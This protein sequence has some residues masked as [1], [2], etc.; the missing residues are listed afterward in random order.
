M[1]RETVS[2][3]VLLLPA[4]YTWW[5]GRRLVRRID[6]PAFPELRMAGSQRLFLVVF[7][8]A[9]VAL[10]ISWRFPAAKVA[11]LAI[12]LIVA[13]FPAR[14]QIYNET[15]G[16][17]GYAAHV[18]RLVVAFFGVWLVLAAAPAIVRGS[19]SAGLPVALGV[20]VL[21]VAW[22]HFG[23][24]LIPRV[25]GAE[26]LRDAALEREFEA[27]Q[28]ELRCPRP[29]LLR[30]DTGGGYW[31]NALALPDYR[32]PAVLFTDDL[33]R[34][35]TPAETTAIYAHEA[36]HLEYFNRRRL[37]L[38]ELIVVIL[39]GFSALAAFVPGIDS[40]FFG[41]LVWAWPL[42]VLL[43]LFVLAAGN[44]AREHDCDVRAAQLTGDAE[45]VVSGLTR[46][47][48]L[49]RM[50]RRWRSG[51]ER[52]VSHPSLANRIR[53]I[54][55]AAGLGPA[56]EKNREVV[57]TELTVRSAVDPSE[58]V[59]LGTDRIHF[60]RGLD[61]ESD[62]DPARVLDEAAESR[63]IRYSDLTDVRLEVSGPR[64]R[65]LTA[66][67]RDGRKQRLALR[68][69]DVARVK[70][71]LE[72]I[73]LEVSG[74]APARARELARE[75]AARGRGRLAAAIVALF[76]LYPFS[77]VALL[78]SSLAVWRPTR[79]TLAACGAMAFVGG[80]IGYRTG[81][82]FLF[83]QEGVA[84]VAAIEA[85]AGI[86]LLHG[87][88]RL[89]GQEM[90]EGGA[91]KLTV[92]ALL[93]MSVLY[94]L[95]ALAR[96]AGPNVITQLHLWAR[97]EQGLTL[98]LVGLSAALL[99]LG[100]RKARVPALVTSAVALLTL[101][102][103]SLAFQARFG[104]D[105][106]S[107][108]RPVRPGQPLTPAR[109]RLLEWE[110][111]VAGLRLSP[112]GN[113]LAVL[114]YPFNA[115]YEGRFGGY[116]VEL[117]DGSFRSI[118]AVDLAFLDDD[119]V[120]A[121]AHDEIGR[122]SL[123]IIRLNPSPATERE[124]LL[125]LVPDPVLRV[126]P[127]LN[128]WQVSSED[129]RAG[130]ATLQFGAL[131]GGEVESVEWKY[132]ETSESVVIGLTPSAMGTALA[133][134]SRYSY[135]GLSYFAA[136]LGM[137]GVYAMPIEL[138]AVSDSSATSLAVTVQ[139]VWCVDAPPDRADIICG[140]NLRDIATRIWSIEPDASAMRLVAA[141]PGFYRAGELGSGDRLLLSGYNVPPL[142]TDLATGDVHPLFLELEMEHAAHDETA[143]DGGAASPLGLLFESAP[144]I[145]YFQAFAVAKEHIAV[146][147]WRDSGSTLAVYRLTDR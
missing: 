43:A 135:G 55:D 46:I 38:R 40:A 138:W 108:E 19:G 63:S 34:A 29:R 134:G 35:L 126:S 112:S 15:W 20:A 136:W 92:T 16:L 113:R 9:A 76:N 101:A 22:N 25:L 51:S 100:K 99:G 30:L 123:R 122:L 79:A 62:L 102:V 10:V 11:V 96:L 106:L 68:S 97:H 42:A 74:T 85:L 107:V 39:A 50:P 89:R 28:S 18:I 32:R 54:R 60:L 127:E 7:V 103:G 31:V 83:G 84:L 142:L 21:L 119:R 133:I 26:P 137:F 91:W 61:P 47:H 110:E 131:D 78:I 24:E 14:R 90:D 71:H 67:D 41:S 93:G 36:A 147:A 145:P 37:L 88:V 4:L 23:S 105:P 121:L 146:A 144:S 58:A 124:I 72:Q 53:A 77:F 128:R 95:G 64:D 104:D 132:P 81:G 13:R 116:R 5:H 80:L 87:A 27:V 65:Y 33:L 82:G 143:A 130:G 8:S 98:A 69:E 56:E 44:Q 125:R 59:M 86:V 45:A 115:S 141:V 3:V 57:R 12:S 120:A 118:D 17:A 129:V 139:S 94:S 1:L 73:D 109:T 49:M 2:F 6:D 140:S 111:G 114:S 66:V 117:D 70:A 48:D 75:A 52:R